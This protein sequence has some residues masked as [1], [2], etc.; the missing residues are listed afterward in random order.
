MLITSAPFRISLFG[1]TTDFCSFYRDWGSLIIGFTIDKYCYVA[2]RYTPKIMDYFTRINY[3]ITETVDNNHDVL[4]N[5]VRGVLDY[6]KI[7]KGVEISCFLDLPARSGIGSSS[8]FVVACLIAMY[9]HRDGK[10]PSKKQIAKDAIYVERTVLQE[11]GGE[12]DQIAISYGGVNSIDIKPNGDFFVRPLPLS[13]EF[14]QYFKDHLVLFYLSQRQSFKIAASVDFCD[15]NAI[16]HKKEILRLSKEAYRRFENEDLRS[17]GSL[18]DESWQHKKSVSNLTS[19][20]EIDIYYQKA[21]DLGSWGGKICGAGGG[22]TILFLVPP[23]KRQSLID[24]IGLPNIDFNFSF[25]GGT[26]LHNK[27]L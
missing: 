9:Y 23:E 10:I 3:S 16:I 8:A 12:Q 25:N 26:L 24:Q 5:G 6:L 21:K 22:G 2:T 13:P 14:L 7:D 17:I 27:G 15:E 18:L 20:T 19:N 1:G 11:S 4:H